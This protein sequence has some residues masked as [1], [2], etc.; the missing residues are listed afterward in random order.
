MRVDRLWRARDRNLVRILDEHDQHRLKLL[1]SCGRQFGVRHGR[2]SPEA[3]HTLAHPEK[4]SGANGA[5]FLLLVRNDRG[6]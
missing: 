6:L 1:K 4:S 5:S 2:P 3:R